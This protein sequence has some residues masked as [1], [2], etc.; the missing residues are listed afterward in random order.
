MTRAESASLHSRDTKAVAQNAD[1]RIQLSAKHREI[2][3]KHLEGYS[4]KVAR[5]VLLKRHSKNEKHPLTI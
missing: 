3:L 2:D 4:S 5:T 1:S